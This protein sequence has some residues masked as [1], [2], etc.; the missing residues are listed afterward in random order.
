MMKFKTV[1]KWLNDNNIPWEETDKQQLI[2]VKRCYASQN[3]FYDYG[4]PEKPLVFDKFIPKEIKEDTR[5][6]WEPC[7]ECCGCAG[8]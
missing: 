1:K 4:E 3:N 8:W 6:Y 2:I 7:E 5:I